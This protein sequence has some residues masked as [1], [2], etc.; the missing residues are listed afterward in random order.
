MF[1][2]IPIVDTQTTLEPYK[3]LKRMFFAYGSSPYGYVIF[4]SF[5]VNAPQK[6][7][8]IDEQLLLSE[9]KKNLRGSVITAPL[10]IKELFHWCD[11][12]SLHQLGAFLKQALKDGKINEQL[13]IYLSTLRRNL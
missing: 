12:H 10:W 1:K 8:N 6:S 2:T 5:A 13:A 9:A 4:H 11:I 3:G 7:L